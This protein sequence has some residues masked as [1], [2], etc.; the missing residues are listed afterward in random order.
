MAFQKIVIAGATGAI[1]R[2]VLA[3]LLTIPT[4]TKITVLTR[5]SNSTSDWPSSSILSVATIT[6]YEDQTVL[7]SIIRGH[8][9]VISTVGGVIGA[10]ADP[11]L[12]SAAISVGVQRFMPSEYSVDVMHPHAIAV[13]GSTVL[14]DRVRNAQALRE[15][16][17]AGEIEYTT[18]VTGAFLDWW[19]E[20]G[21][22]GVHVKE[23]RVTLY[24]GGDKPAT[25]STTE[26]IAECVG[27]I[28][29]MPPE[30]TKNRRIRIAEVKYS[31]KEIAA[32]FQA[33]TGEKWAV[34]EKSTAALLEEGKKAFAKGDARGF[35]LANILA[36][37]F[38]GEGA[39]FFEEGL[40][41]GDGQVKRRSLREIVDSVAGPN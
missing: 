40:K 20:G 2:K 25:G 32:T 38:D 6:S 11:L 27:A 19:F 39:A 26:F 24:D 8:D 35:Y 3:H 16:A 23:K 5:R 28:V 13:A 30:T 9:L 4:V 33:A 10:V 36:L 17:E 15:R 12:L 7:T 37:N 21:E 29:T 31:G 1:G 18:L 41:F 34:E 22:L 14:A